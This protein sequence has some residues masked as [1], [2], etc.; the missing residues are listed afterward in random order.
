VN[1][2]S[3]LARVAIPGSSAYAAVKGAIEVFT[4]Y[5]RLE[6]KV[7]LVTGSGRGIGRA[8]AE[9][10]ASLGAKVVVNYAGDEKRA[11]EVVAAIERSGGIAWF[12]WSW[13]LCRSAA[14]PRNEGAEVGSPFM[15]RRT[16]EADRCRGKYQDRLG[17][18]FILVRIKRAA[19]PMI[20]RASR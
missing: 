6:D 4:H 11:R 9:R 18:L 2:S 8:I 13:F 16:P 1:I 7:A 20:A 5:R 19:T 15:V 10:Y 12:T 14:V 17:Q 3:G